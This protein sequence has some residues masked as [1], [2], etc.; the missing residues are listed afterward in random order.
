MSKKYNIIIVILGVISLI[1]GIHFMSNGVV[2][3]MEAL[4]E[5]FI[6]TANDAKDSKAAVERLSEALGEDLSSVSDQVKVLGVAYYMLLAGVIV[7]AIGI[8]GCCLTKFKSWSE[9]MLVAFVIA[10][11]AGIM[12]T[13]FQ[14]GLQESV[15]QTLGFFGSFVTIDG[16]GNK[17]LWVN[18]VLLLISA[19]LTILKTKT[20]GE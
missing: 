7:A 9:L 1:F 14:K 18:G 20:K 6:L 2:F 13:T 19:F 12:Y 3:S 10:I 4:S 17:I 8:L 11:I 5:K 15:N 16:E